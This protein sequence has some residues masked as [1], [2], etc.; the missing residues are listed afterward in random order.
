VAPIAKV[1]TI[2]AA[3]EATT[4]RPWPLVALLEAA[5]AIRAALLLEAVLRKS[6]ADAG[7]R[8]GGG[9]GGDGSGGE[10]HAELLV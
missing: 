6:A 4:V 10:G 8:E 7:E 5:V 1:L 3:V 2:G 9:D